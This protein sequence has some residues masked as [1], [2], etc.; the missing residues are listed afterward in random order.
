MH[1]PEYQGRD[2]F[3]RSDFR[4]LLLADYQDAIGDKALDAVDDL[5]KTTVSQFSNLKSFKDA[6]AQKT[7][8]D[9]YYKYP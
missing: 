1:K 4:G 7:K 6:L 9:S 3:Q 8:V 5:N 2:F